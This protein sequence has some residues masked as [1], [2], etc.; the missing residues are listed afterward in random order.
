VNFSILVKVKKK[1][2]TLSLPALKL[3]IGNC[4]EIKKLTE[5]KKKVAKG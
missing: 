5:G 3:E 1:R 2:T 4:K